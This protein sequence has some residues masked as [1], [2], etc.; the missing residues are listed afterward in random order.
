MALNVRTGTAPAPPVFTPVI[1]S[2]DELCNLKLTS[3]VIPETGGSIHVLQDLRKNPKPNQP[4]RNSNS[5]RHL[6]GSIKEPAEAEIENGH[7]HR[8][9]DEIN[10][11]AGKSV[12]L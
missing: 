8:G 2:G 9:A 11:P 5:K 10:G 3:R 4:G 6:D 7:E 1:W 12:L